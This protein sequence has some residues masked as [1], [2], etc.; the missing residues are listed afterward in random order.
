MLMPKAT[1][2]EDYGLALFKNDVWISGQFI[3]MQPKTKA[4]FVHQTTDKKF[5]LHTLTFNLLHIL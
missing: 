2:N 4:H 5:G 3:Y 1:V